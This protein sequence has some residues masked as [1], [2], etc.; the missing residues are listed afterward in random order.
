MSG[1]TPVFRIFSDIYSQWWDNTPPKTGGESTLLGLP[2]YFLKFI[3]TLNF[4]LVSELET[5]VAGA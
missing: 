2:L 5:N 3:F 1:F 4:L